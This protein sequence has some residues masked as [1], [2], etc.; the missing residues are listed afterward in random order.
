MTS[1][2]PLQVNAELST[3]ARWSLVN[4]E[5]S[6]SVVTAIGPIFFL[7]F[8]ILVRLEFEIKLG[9]LLLS[10]AAATAAAATPLLF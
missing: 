4:V 1:G 2:H 3:M 9:P 6:G 7:F 8:G 10:S 5:P